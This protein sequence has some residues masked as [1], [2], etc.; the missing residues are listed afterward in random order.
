MGWTP[1]ALKDWADFQARLQVH[2]ARLTARGVNYRGP[3]RYTQ[4]GTWTPEQ[5]S[6]QFKVMEW[7]VTEQIKE[8]ATY[9]FTVW[10]ERGAARP[11]TEW[12]ALLENGHEISRDAHAGATGAENKKNEYRLNVPKRDANAKYVLRA[13]VRSAGGTDSRGGI[14]LSH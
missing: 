11:E 14:W 7:D 13:S 9:G 10:Y 1:A 12:A 4:V 6:E 3:S 8:S 2:S 5:M